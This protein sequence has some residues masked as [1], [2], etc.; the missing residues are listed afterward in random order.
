MAQQEEPLYDFPEPTQ[1]S[2]HKF[3]GHQRGRASLRSISVLDRLLLTV[4]VWFQ[5]SINPATA[6]HIM[7]RE[8]PGAFLVRKSRTSQRNVLCV[9]LADDSVPSFVQQFGIREE[10]STLR[11]ETSAISFPDLPRL[12][13]FYCI[14]RDVLPFPLELPEAIAKA[15]S[16]KELESISHMGIEFWSSQLNVRGPREAP[17]PQKN[18]EKKPDTVTS[19]LTAAAP[20]TSSASQP[21]SAPQPD[22]DNHLKTAHESDTASKQ[23]G[24]NPTLFR[25]FCPITT[26]SP[27][28]L[29][30]GSG[31]GALC[32]VN[33]LFLQSQNTL[34][35]RR[36][37][38]HSVKV[39]VS[40]ETS[41]MLSPPFAPPPPPPLMPK[42]KRKCTVQKCG[43]ET[44]HP[45]EGLGLLQ[46]ENPSQA[47]QILTVQDT[48][49]QPVIQAQVEPGPSKAGVMGEEATVQLPTVI[50]QLP[51]VSDYMQ[52]SAMISFSHSPVVSPTAP[53]L[54]PKVSSSSSPHDSPGATP[55]L[56]PY[57]SPCSS[58]MA[59]PLFPKVSSSRSPHDS[60]SAPPNTYLSPSSYPMAPPLFP[61]V[62]SARSHDLASP[63]LSPHQSP[64]LSPKV[65][66][67]LSPCDSPSAS[68]PLSQSPSPPKLTPYISPITSPSFSQLVEQAYHTPASSLRSDHQR[69]VSEAEEEGA[70]VDQNE[71]EDDEELHKKREEEER[72]L[73]LQMNA[74]SLNETDSCSSFS[75]VEVAAETP[76]HSPYKQEMVQASSEH[77]RL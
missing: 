1:P 11:L 16:H 73:V 20:Q 43:Q 5:L 28:E 67:S 77:F 7:Q 61:K 72:G 62:S 44:A 10:H 30:C 42:T 48:R 50:E 71:D 69:P 12:I 55:N 27:K 51:D 74:A 29:D 24:L 33:P 54:F 8:P 63:S 13:S 57:L 45:S 9:R 4:P 26:R 35:R 64:S 70:G 68:P 75:S 17:K 6:L 59:P 49:T 3:L 66:F 65:V 23:S 2:V 53:S 22:L 14:S 32:F 60:P 31:Q 56:S 58:P 38:K 37:F 40:T 41:T 36:M 15:T 25:E 34:S 21:N 18:M 39:R 52:P 47:I 46:G 76:S 19:A